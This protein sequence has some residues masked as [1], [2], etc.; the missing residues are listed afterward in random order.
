MGSNDVLTSQKKQ[1]KAIQSLINLIYENNTTDLKA[2]N[3][4][5][6]DSFL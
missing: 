4:I 1:K 5:V 6:I 2:S 3:S